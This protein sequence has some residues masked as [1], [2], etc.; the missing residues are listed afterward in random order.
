MIFRTVGIL[1]ISF[2]AKV[3]VLPRNKST[4]RFDLNVLVTYS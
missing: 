1:K 3:K 2:D 4:L